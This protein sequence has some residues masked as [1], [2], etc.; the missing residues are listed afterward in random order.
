MVPSPGTEP[1]TVN[2]V[3][4]WVEVSK[5]AVGDA[6]FPSVVLHLLPTLDDFGALDDDLFAGCGLVDDA[7]PVGLAATRWVDPFAINALMHRN[8]IAGLG[9]P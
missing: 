6:D 1:V 3:A 2:Q 9:Q 5:K 8:Y 7:L 4:V